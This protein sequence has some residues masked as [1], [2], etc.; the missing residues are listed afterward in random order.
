MQRFRSY[1]AV[2]ALASA[3]GAHA[4]AAQS[5]PKIDVNGKWMFNVTTS[6]G[7]GTSTRT[8][9]TFIGGAVDAHAGN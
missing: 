6:A 9:V 1:L 3:F 7:N 4:A 5:G 8:Q 2:L